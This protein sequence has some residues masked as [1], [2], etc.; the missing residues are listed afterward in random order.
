M[1]FTT[2]VSRRLH[3]EHDAT[4]AL[5]GRVQRVAL[6]PGTDARTLLAQ[7]L[8]AL[9][10]EIGR[11]FEFEEQAL[12][13]RL[14]AAGEGDIGE[15]LTEEHVVIRQAAARM[16]SALAGERFDAART[17]ALELSE[18]I[19][20]HVDK[21]EKALLPAVDDALDQATDAALSMEYAET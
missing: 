17:I 14:A 9:E 19:L 4:L 1:S 18:L 5:W 13:P 20:G 6:Q 8:A 11:H 10:G 15:L 7:A 16:K 3:E 21:E 12:F 2:Q